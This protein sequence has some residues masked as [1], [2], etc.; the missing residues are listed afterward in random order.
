[1]AST[2]RLHDYIVRMDGG[3]GG[4]EVTA[5]PSLSAAV[6][7]AREWAAGAYWPTADGRPSCEHTVTVESRDGRET[8]EFAI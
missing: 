8:D 3:D 5:Q 7:W 2:A 4:E 1:M 6:A